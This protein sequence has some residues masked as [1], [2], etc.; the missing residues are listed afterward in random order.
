MRFKNFL[1]ETKWK[2][3]QLRKGNPF[4]VYDKYEISKQE[5][6]T[7]K[8]VD[9]NQMTGNEYKELGVFTSLKKAQ[10]SIYET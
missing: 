3:R 10:D 2:R 5:D 9:I 1:I 7:F 6:G 8:L 4:W